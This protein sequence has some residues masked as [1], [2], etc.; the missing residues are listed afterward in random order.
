LED[1]YYSIFKEEF[2]TT[3]KIGKKMQVRLERGWVVLLTACDVRYILLSA[4]Q[5]I[6]YC[7]QLSKKISKC[8]SNN[9]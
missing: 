6:T 2:P 9:V 7:S 5:K 1:L 3:G 8:L 4:I